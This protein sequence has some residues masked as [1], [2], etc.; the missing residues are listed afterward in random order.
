M[1]KSILKPPESVAASLATAGLVYA[2]YMHAMPPMVEIH[3]AAP[4][5]GSVESSRKK[6][7]WT[8]IAVASGFFLLTKDPNVWIAGGLTLV[9]I[10][11]QVRHANAVSPAT[12][13]MVPNAQANNLAQGYTDTPAMGDDYTP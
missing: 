1:F 13:K 6:A 2:V 12:G 10:D 11:W 7:M 4:Q 3:A 5:D 9:A 8:S